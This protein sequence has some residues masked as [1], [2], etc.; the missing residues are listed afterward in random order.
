[1]AAGL[2]AVARAPA[3]LAAVINTGDDEEFYGLH[4]SPDLDTVLYTLAGIVNP[5]TGWGIAG[6]GQG[7]F[8]EAVRRYGAPAW[9]YLGDRDLATHVLRTWWLRQGRTLS[10]VTGEL[11]S[12]LGVA[13]RLL[14][15]SDQPVRTR[16]S[17]ELGGS[18]REI[19]FQEYFVHLQAGPPV[20]R[21][22]FEGAEAAKPAP[23][24]LEALRTAQA[25]IIAPSNPLLS[26]GPILAVPGIREAL[27]ER[28]GRVAVSP[29]VGGRAFKGPTAK[30]MGELGLRA[31]A[32]G[33]AALYRGLVDA[34]LM[35][36]CDAP[37]AGDVAALGIQ[38]VLTG[39]GLQ[40]DEDRR[41]TAATALQVA[42]DP[43]AGRSPAVHP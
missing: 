20:R 2:A 9:F 21:L 36:P 18:E 32:A 7:A 8:M 4:V 31:D 5:V 17:V 27:A 3:D 16:L 11:A 24:V 25:V 15:M 38:P 43:R 26:I 10:E 30:V 33:V 40:T 1:M 39:I 35:D 6:D 37:L 14:P 42:L 23:G 13:V 28:S 19:A 41:R 12:R 29:L 22:R 34:F